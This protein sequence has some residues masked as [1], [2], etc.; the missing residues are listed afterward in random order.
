MISMVGDAVGIRGVI[1]IMMSTAR[2]VSSSGSVDCR[3]FYCDYYVHHL[4]LAND[5]LRQKPGG[6]NLGG[7]LCLS[8]T[9][10]VLLVY[11]YL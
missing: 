6:K 2:R 10:S 4:C 5:L 1:S 8:T 9:V 3:L 11:L 7:F